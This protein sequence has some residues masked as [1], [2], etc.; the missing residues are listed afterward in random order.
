QR[1]PSVCMPLSATC[2]ALC[3]PARK[4]L[5]SA[6]TTKRLGLI[7]VGEALQLVPLSVSQLCGFRSVAHRTKCQLFTLPWGIPRE[8][9]NRTEARLVPAWNAPPRNKG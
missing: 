2:S 3:L 4:A 7:D 8:A 5:A 6:S 9:Q 1:L